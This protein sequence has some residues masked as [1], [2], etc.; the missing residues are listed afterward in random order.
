MPE[1]K[2]PETFRRRDPD[3]RRKKT[4]L[5]QN[6]KSDFFSFSAVAIG[7]GKS[8]VALKLEVELDLVLFRKKKRKIELKV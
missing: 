7:S 1:K 4:F 6:R 8:Q 3:F 5:P 2:S